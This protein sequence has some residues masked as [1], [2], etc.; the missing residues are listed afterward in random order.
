MVRNTEKRQFTNYHNIQL[1][2][3]NVNHKY[4]VSI[5]KNIAKT[6]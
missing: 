2:K 5:L 3:D 6:L 1:K 4:R